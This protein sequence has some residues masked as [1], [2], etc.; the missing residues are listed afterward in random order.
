M[1]LDAILS[2]VEPL[3]RDPYG[4]DDFGGGFAETPSRPVTEGRASGAQAPEA[5]APGVRAS[6]PKGGFN[7]AATLR[8]NT[9]PSS[10]SS[11]E[12]ED[13]ED[14]PVFSPPPR[15]R[16]VR[17]EAVRGAP[18]ATHRA[19][20][21]L[22]EQGEDLRG[23]LYRQAAALEA[24]AAELRQRAGA[25]G[26]PVPPPASEA[27]PTVGSDPSGDDTGESLA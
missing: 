23:F 14:E 2:K 3:E 20:G 21:V 24:Q 8:T 9:A 11:A 27:T 15:P 16:T 1:D 26:A 4:Q 7:F 18:Q 25:L 22:S 12:D 5:R 17:S 19:Q 6:I 10:S 13:A